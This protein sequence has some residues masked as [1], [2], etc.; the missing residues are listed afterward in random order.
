MCNEQIP[1]EH[2]KQILKWEKGWNIKMIE[3]SGQHVDKHTGFYFLDSDLVKAWSWGCLQTVG[4]NATCSLACLIQCKIKSG[5]RWK[6]R[7]NDESRQVRLSSLFHFDAKCAHTSDDAVE[8]K[9][10]M[11]MAREACVCLAVHCQPTE[12]PVRYHLFTQVRLEWITD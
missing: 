11:G 3:R 2:K 6:R 4:A 8:W 9:R 12:E 7:A 10:E 1:A 5:P